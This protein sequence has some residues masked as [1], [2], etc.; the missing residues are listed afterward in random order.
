MDYNEPVLTNYTLNTIGVPIDNVNEIGTK[1]ASSFAV[2]P[3]PA[4]SS[5]T[6]VIN[7]DA[8]HTTDLAVCDVTGKVMITQTLALT[9]G[10]QNVT[11]DISQL[12]PGIYFI[13]LNNNGKTQTQ[14]LVIIK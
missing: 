2:Y 13:V 12:A 7:S 11:T 5:F 9:K 3:N 4:S 10:T 1:P 6:A 14:K 8:T